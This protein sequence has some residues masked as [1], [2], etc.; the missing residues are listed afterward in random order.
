MRSLGRSDGGEDSLKSRPGDIG[1]PRC[2]LVTLDVNFG[3]PVTTGVLS[4]VAS[5][6]VDWLLFEDKWL[7]DRILMRLVTDVPSWPDALG[8][9]SL[10]QLEVFCC[11]REL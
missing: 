3:I 7:V 10:T 5:I 11:I 8:T 1:S 4:T 9:A 6:K 2:R